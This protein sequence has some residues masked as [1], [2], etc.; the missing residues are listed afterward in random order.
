M[1]RKTF[2]LAIK[3]LEKYGWVKRQKGTLGKPDRYTPQIGFEIPE[4]RWM[5]E[6]AKETQLEKE[7]IKAEE[8]HLEWG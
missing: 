4:L 1:E 5:D 8:E 7:R 2:M 6:T 3:D